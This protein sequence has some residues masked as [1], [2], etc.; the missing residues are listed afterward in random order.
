VARKG[1]FV[2]TPSR[3]FPIEFH[4]VLP[5]I[6]WLPV[7]FYRKLLPQI[8]AIVGPRVLCRRELLSRR[9]LSQMARAAGM[10]RFGIGPVSLFGLPT[11]LARC[12]D[13]L[14]SS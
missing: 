8:A 4:T 13:N 11:N 7:S 5:F 3:G 1:V 6:H 9:R 14:G 2:R 12:P 10:E